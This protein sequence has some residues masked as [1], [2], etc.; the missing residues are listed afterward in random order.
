VVRKLKLYYPDGTPM[1]HD[2]CRW[3]LR[4]R[5]AGLFMEWK[6]SPNGQTAHAFGSSLIRRRCVC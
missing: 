1:P 2:E 5:R 6:L 3:L 4:S